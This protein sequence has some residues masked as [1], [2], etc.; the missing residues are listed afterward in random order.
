MPTVAPVAFISHAYAVSSEW[1]R[2][3]M[4]EVRLDAHRG[5]EDWAGICIGAVTALSPWLTGQTSDSAAVMNAVIVGLIVMAF[6]ILEIVRLHRLE[7]IALFA[8][9]LWL[10]VSPFTHGYGGNLALI[11][12]VLGALLTLLAALE[13]W[14]DWGRTD[15]DMARHGS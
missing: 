9:G 10:F 4:A 8:C 2:L 5:W 15:R 7:E 1:R 13:L 6:G 3:P 14:Q 12:T 11:H